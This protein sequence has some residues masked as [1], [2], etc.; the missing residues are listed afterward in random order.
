MMSKPIPSNVRCWDLRAKPRN[1]EPSLE[2]LGPPASRS[3][4]G[5]GE[6]HFSDVE[7]V[8]FAREEARHV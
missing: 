5:L 8:R 4:D 3:G 1:P 2:F 7:A 6:K